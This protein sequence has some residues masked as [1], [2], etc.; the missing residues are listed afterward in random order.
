MSMRRRYF[1]VYNGA[2][3]ETTRKRWLLYMRTWKFS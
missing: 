2:A 1:R 3:I